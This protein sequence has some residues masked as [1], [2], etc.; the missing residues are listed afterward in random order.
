MGWTPCEEKDETMPIGEQYRCPYSDD[1]TSEMCVQ[2]EWEHNRSSYL[3]IEE[4]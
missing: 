1:P 4:V 2:C 3:P